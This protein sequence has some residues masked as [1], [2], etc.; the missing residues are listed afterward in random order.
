MEVITGK[1]S[2]DLWIEEALPKLESRKMFMPLRPMHLPSLGEEEEETIAHQAE[3]DE[4]EYETF[5]GIQ[6]WDRLSVQIL[7]LD[8]FFQRLLDGGELV[9]QNEI[10]D[11]KLS[12]NQKPFK[13]L[14][15]F[16]SNDFLG[17][18]RHPAIAKATAKAAVEH[19]TGPR[20]SPVICGYT[21]YH[22]ALESSLAKLKK[23][24]ACP[25]CPTGFTANMTALVAIG[26]VA[27]L[28]CEGSKPT[29]EEKIA[30]FSDALNH[31]SIIDGI[32]LAQQYGWVEC[33]VYKHCDMSH[34]DELLTNCRMKRKVVVTDS[35]FSMD[36]DF[37]PI[38]ELAELRK[39]HGFLFVL[40]EAH[41]TFVW[42]KNGGGVAEEFKCENDVDISIGTLSKGAASLGGFIA[43]SKNWKQ[44]IQSRGRSFIFSAAAPVPLAA[45]SY[46]SIV[47][48]R[49][50]SWR[51]MEIRKRMQEFQSLTGIQVTS[52]ILSIII[53]SA[54]ETLKGS[55][56]LLVSGIFVTPI[57]GPPAVPANTGRLRVTL[58]AAHTTEDIERLVAVLSDHVNFPSYRKL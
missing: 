52:Q 56:A 22:I 55:Q 26:S 19:G 41:G 16:A 24:E 38:V 35:L 27:Q 15:V 34:L 7:V 20:G 8:T 51:R 14:L 37:A 45:S 21:N 42:G 23:K 3:A 1:S 53:G 12:P 43:C 2:W 25:L 49:K 32:K 44:F 4:E 9:C 17:L 5:Q 11:V 58:T 57:L 39:K 28:L 30:V 47:V 29:K 48:A 40:D 18:G 10:E 31:A 33:F 50:E 6:P 54:E 36:G 46:A 13:K